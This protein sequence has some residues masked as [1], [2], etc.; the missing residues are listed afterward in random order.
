M[1][2]N[3]PADVINHLEENVWLDTNCVICIRILSQVAGKSMHSH[4]F[5]TFP[6]FLLDMKKLAGVVP[7]LPGTRRGTRR[8][9]VCY[10]LPCT[11]ILQMLRLRFSNQFGVVR[12]ACQYG[13]SP[14]SK[15]RCF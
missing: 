14:N 13:F 11:Y 1:T 9:R 6:A 8:L 5:Y 4:V 3:K 2:R 15:L 10:S 7:R 12:R